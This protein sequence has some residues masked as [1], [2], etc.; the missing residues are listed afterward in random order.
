MNRVLSLLVVAG[1]LLVFGDCR[2]DEP[3]HHGPVEVLMDD[4]IPQS[5]EEWRRRLSAEQYRILRQQ[6]LRRV[7]PVQVSC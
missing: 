6:G 5:D 3:Q 1:L 4:E 2:Q 7:G